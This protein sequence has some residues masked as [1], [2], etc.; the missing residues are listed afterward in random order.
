M[1]E[2]PDCAQGCVSSVIVSSSLKCSEWQWQD[3]IV[4]EFL[5]Y[6]CQ[7]VTEILQGRKI[8]GVVY[9]VSVSVSACDCIAKSQS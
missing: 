7:H 5:F 8:K 2:L 1:Q 4:S 6:L 9:F 3:E